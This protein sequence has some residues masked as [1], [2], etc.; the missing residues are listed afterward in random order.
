VKTIISGPAEKTALLFAHQLSIARDCDRLIIMKRGK[1]VSLDSWD[2]L[3]KNDPTFR[4]LVSLR[5]D[6]Q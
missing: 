4:V 1:I 2:F 6:L 5:K 3:P